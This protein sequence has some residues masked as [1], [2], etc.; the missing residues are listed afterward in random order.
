MN[1]LEL[2]QTRLHLYWRLGPGYQFGIKKPRS[3]LERGLPLDRE[4]F[5][6]RPLFEA[7]NGLSLAF[8]DVVAALT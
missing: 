6:L 4:R 2:W 7:F 8:A 5:Y 1:W 3:G